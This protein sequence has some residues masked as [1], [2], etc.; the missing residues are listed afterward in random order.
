MGR[1]HWFAEQHG[2]EVGLEVI[3]RAWRMF[4]SLQQ[5]VGQNLNLR[6]ANKSFENMAELI[7]LGT[8]PTNKNGVHG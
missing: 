7:Y 4:A 5:N 6:I 1:K 3:E 8:T 2:K